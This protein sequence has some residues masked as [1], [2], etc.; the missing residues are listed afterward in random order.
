MEDLQKLPNSKIVMPF[1]IYNSLKKFNLVYV[2]TIY[3]RL[4][5]ATP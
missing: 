5:V 2:M 1:E 3:N 4:G